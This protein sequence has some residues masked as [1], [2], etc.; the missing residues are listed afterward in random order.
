MAKKII[1]LILEIVFWILIIIFAYQ[2]LLKILGNSPTDITLLYT[3]FGVI[4]SYLLIATYHFA[5]FTGKAE[6]FMDNSKE[7]FKRVKEDINKLLN[8]R[9]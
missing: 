2:L 1:Q 4:T 6:E 9:N 3:G 8:N 7:S 5:K